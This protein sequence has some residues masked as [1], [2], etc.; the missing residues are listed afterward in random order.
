MTSERQ[1][2]LSAP[3]SQHGAVSGSTSERQAAANETEEQEATPLPRM[4]IFIVCLLRAAEPIALF[5][6]FPTIN[7]QLHELLPD[8]PAERIGYYSG[9][10]ESAFALCQFIVSP[11]WGRLSD[12]VG[13]KPVLIASMC[14]LCVSMNSFGLSTSFAMLIA[15]RCINGL[16]GGTVGILRTIL[17]ESTDSTN[18]ARAF[19]LLPIFFSVGSIIGPWLGAEFS[20]PAETFPAL[21]F[22]FLRKHPFWLPCGIVSIYVIFVVAI[23]ALYL[24]ET[25]PA[26]ARKQE[27][28]RLRADAQ[29][30]N[31]ADTRGT[32]DE[33][34]ALLTGQELEQEADRIESRVEAQ[35]A[36]V[37][38]PS[39]RSLLT[40]ERVNILT[41][42]MLLNLMNISWTSLVPL[43]CFE[44]VGYGGVGL[45]KEGIGRLL[46]SQGIL[47]IIVQTFLFPWAEKRMKG[48]LPVYK[49][50]LV[51]FLPA[52]CSLPLAHFVAQR[53]DSSTWIWAPLIAGT[54]FKAL[55]GMAIVCATLLINNCAPRSALGTINGLSQS[56]G[57]LSR[58]IGPTAS[59]SL[60]AFS[61][62]H[63]G[64]GWLTWG[65]C[66]AVAAATW[67]ASQRITVNKPRR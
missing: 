38:R 55:T 44:Q 16:F 2:L 32:D 5:I 62:T 25:H 15:S 14:G 50:S 42:Q 9:L 6:I 8:V 52:F 49:L 18:S 36:K 63:A 1:P 24:E 27:A 64:L 66:L 29:Q 21:D 48:P 58:A 46:A 19:S 17:G 65:C 40:L 26:K 7:F 10:V 57:S 41:T 11:L 47:S 34:Q 3:Q 59:T 67:A 51:F 28:E 60:F 53:T 39:L 4:Q 56:F 23:A 20:H 61:S 31:A 12:R 30:R 43:F 13:R 22:A 54:A 35:E 45:Q 37:E 33:R